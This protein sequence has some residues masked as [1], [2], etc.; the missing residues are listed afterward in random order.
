[1]P[2]R[3]AFR[4]QSYCRDQ[5]SENWKLVTTTHLEGAL[6]SQ[7][8]S[9]C[10][11]AVQQLL[12]LNIR[13]VVLV[14]GTLAGTDVTGLH[15]EIGRVVPKLDAR[16]GGLWKQVIDT[17]ARDRCNYTQPFA[18]RVAA[19]SDHLSVSRFLWSS[20]NH[21]L[22]RSEAALQL[23]VHLSQL[24]KDGRIM[25]WGHSHAG[26]VFALLTNLLGGDMETRQEMFNALLPVRRRIHGWDDAYKLLLGSGQNEIIDPSR[27]DIVTF[28]T[29]IRYGWDSDGYDRLLHITNHRPME[30]VPPYCVPFPPH[31]GQVVGAIAGDFIQQFFIAGTNFVPSL[32]SARKWQAERR[33]HKM[34]QRGLGSK[35][36]WEA[37]SHGCRVADEGMNLLIDY[38]ASGDA[39]AS[40]F[41]GHAVYTRNKWAPFHLSLVAEQFDS[42][43]G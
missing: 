39:T 25:L 9:M 24:P 1:M 42:T 40:E 8:D 31:S 5:P 19:Y 26:N 35:R 4:H 32:I 6:E 2:E 20:E 43:N 21:H 41:C 27:L 29:P 13:Q 11:R 12:D 28:G 3:N 15:R 37:L 22:G 34:L 7:F 18:D 33:L 17:Y 36:L 23:A 14:H 10:Q 30:G 16:V 38:L